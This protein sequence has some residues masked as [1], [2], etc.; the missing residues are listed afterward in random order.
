MPK[1]QYL[2][3]NEYSKRILEKAPKCRHCKYFGEVHHMEKGRDGKKHEV[4]LCVAH[5]GCFNT[6]NSLGCD[7]WSPIVSGMI[8]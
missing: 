1:P 8:R 5:A 6:W 3:D 2:E 7:D 4:Y